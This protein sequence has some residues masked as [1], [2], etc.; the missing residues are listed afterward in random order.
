MYDVMYYSGIVLTITFFTLSIFIF[1]YNNIIDVYRYYTKGKSKKY[2]KVKKR[3]NNVST[4]PSEIVTGVGGATEI[5]GSANE[6]TERLGHE[7]YDKSHSQS[8]KEL[9]KTEILDKAQNF[10]AALFEADKTEILPRYDE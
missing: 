4:V 9:E 1:F 3:R 2:I 6:P 5:L 7:Y 8:Q 10:A